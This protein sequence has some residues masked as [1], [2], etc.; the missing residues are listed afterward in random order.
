MRVWKNILLR[1]SWWKYAGWWCSRL[2]AS[3]EGVSR[4]PEE[5][6]DRVRR[7]E[8]SPALFQTGCSQDD[9]GGVPIQ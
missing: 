9:F 6:A 7:P 4:L 3:A 1:T 2:C 5:D 8:F